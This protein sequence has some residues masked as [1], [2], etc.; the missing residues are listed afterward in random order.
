MGQRGILMGWLA[1]SATVGTLYLGACA[2]LTLR[3]QRIRRE[4]EEERRQ[5]LQKDAVRRFKLKLL[6]IQLRRENREELEALRKYKEK[7]DRQTNKPDWER[8]GF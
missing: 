8:E 6:L 3:D 2:Y 4:K 5:Q 7:L 1:V